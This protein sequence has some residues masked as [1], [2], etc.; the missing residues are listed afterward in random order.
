MG[1]IHGAAKDV[2]APRETEPPELRGLALVI[3]DVGQ[4]QA[5]LA[6]LLEVARCNTS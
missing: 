3:H 6:A 2:R 4:L 5:E 1:R